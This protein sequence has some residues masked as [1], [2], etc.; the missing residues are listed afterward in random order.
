MTLV[1]PPAGSQRSSVDRVW[2]ALDAGGFKPESI[3][4]DKFMALCP[5]HGDSNR[6]LS[7]K[8]ESR[9][10]MTMLH[11]F[12]CQAEYR[13]IAA[14]IHLAPS[15]LF[16]E[17]LPE[18]ERGERKK[19]TPRTKFVPTHKVP[20][21]I[22]EDD[23]AG[24][25]ERLKKATWQRVLTYPY[26]DSKG[27]VIE[28]VIREQTVLDG[29]T[30]K[31]FRQRF[32]GDK[33]RW[34]TKKPEWF[35]P[36]LY[37]H[38]QLLEAIAAGSPVW[39]VEGEKDAD[40]A[41]AAGL[42][43]TTNAQ[44]A[45]SF[46]EELIDV[47]A[48][49]TVKVVVDRDAAGYKRGVTMHRLL[50]GVAASVTLLRPAVDEDKSDLS[51]HLEAG[52]G[53]DELEEITAR[54]SAL[55]AAVG[56][57]HRTIKAV[58]VCRR[59]I[60][61]HLERIPAAGAA[62]PQHR[63]AAETWAT[64]SDI[65][66]RRMVDALTKARIEY[67]G[68]D[69]ITHAALNDADAII[70][71]A[72]EIAREAHELAEVRTPVSI[73]AWRDQGQ[74][75]APIEAVSDDDGDDQQP[76]R[77]TGHEFIP[78]DDGTPNIGTEYRVRN[79]QTV[80]VKYVP[81]EEGGWKPRFHLI[82]D[83]WAEILSAS[84]EDDGD[85]AT[86]SPLS[87]MIVEFSR[88]SRDPETG[89]PLYDEN[90]EVIVERQV[91]VWDEE[92]LREGK[93]TNHLGWPGMLEDSSRRGR[94]MAWNAIHR[95]RRAPS[96]FNRIYT[97]TG[98]RKTDLG[99]FFVHGG[100]AITSQGHLDVD[101]RMPSSIQKLTVPEPTL[102][103]KVLREA[104]IRGTVSLREKLP[105][106][107]IAPLLGLVWEAPFA[108]V[109]L[110][111][112]LEGAPGSGKSSC[113]RQAMHYFAPELTDRVGASKTIL[114]ATQAGGS[115][116]GMIRLLAQHV[117]H[118]PVLA[119]DFVDAQ[120]ARKAEAKI[121]NFARAIF[122]RAPRVIG[123]AR[124]GTSESKPIDAS[125][126][127]TGQV[128]L[129]GSGLQ[130]VFTID[131]S[132]GD[133]VDTPK[134][135]ADL[136]KKDRR[137][138]RAVLGA[139]LI[140]WL[141]KHRR[142]LEAEF[143]D[144]DTPGR[145][146]NEALSAMWLE[147]ISPLPHS[148]GA[149]GRMT[150]AA[151]AATHGIHIMLRMLVDVD[152]IT[153]D[154]ANEFLEWAIDG[155]LTAIRR[156]DHGAGD[157]GMTT[158]EL[159]REGLATNMAHLTT[160]EGEAPEHAQQF[161][162]TL[163]G[164]PPHDMLLPNGPRIGAIKGTGADAKLLLHP[165]VTYELISRVARG[166]G[167]SLSDTPMSIGSSFIAH[168]WVVPDNG[169]K[170]AVGRRIE[171][172][173]QRVW[174]IPLTVL[175]GAD[176]DDGTP[177]PENG[178]TG[179][180]QPSEGPTT[181]QTPSLFDVDPA[182]AGERPRREPAVDKPET[183]AAAGPDASA[184]PT[185]S[186]PSAP[187]PAAARPTAP[188]KTTSPFAAAV[189]VLHVDGLWMP[190]G[191]RLELP[192]PLRHLG[193]VA[194]LIAHLR[195]GVKNGWKNEDGQLFVT[196]GAAQQL[197]LPMEDLPKPGTF[198]FTEELK[199]RTKD[200][201]FITDAIDAGWQVGGTERSLNATTRVWHP[202]NPQLRGRFVLIPA[203]KDDFAP[204]MA[205][206]T[207]PA[208]VA[209][210]LQRFADALGA[211]YAVSAS[212]T[213]LDLMMTTAPSKEQRLLRFAPSEPVPP[214]EI[215]TLEA[216]INWQRKPTEE[217]LT[218]RYVHGFDRGGS[219]LAGVAGL[220][221]GVGAPTYLPE[222]TPITFDKNTPGYWRV[223]MPEKAEWLTPNPLDPRNRDEDTTGQLTWVS[224]PTLEIA[225]DCGYSFEIQEA[226]VWE[227]HTRLLDTWYERVRD[228]RTALDTGDPDDT[229][230]RDLLK[231]LY[232]R[233]L[234]LMASHEHHRGRDGYAPERYH[235]IQAKARAAI[236]RRIHQIGKNTGRWPVAIIAD[237]VLY[238]S[239]EID[240]AKAWPGEARNFGRGLGQFKPEGF[241]ELAG[242][243]KFLTG[244]GRYEG[245][246]FLDQELI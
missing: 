183:P 17:P 124:G 67:S 221:L 86:A 69:P 90:G 129:H 5:V 177:A 42:V 146:S 225:L 230:A 142:A 173:L 164:N 72:A 116:I 222:G 7:V 223:P 93:W 244:R 174:E 53:V 212:T 70:E 18:N 22:T 214:A 198:D 29:V 110:I 15:D 191:E 180:Q 133:I 156:Q 83:G 205:G 3:R 10:G 184:Q 215:A 64:E 226:Y 123:K 140:Q 155:I 47:F 240:P 63:E 114:S 37:H 187:A 150:K 206:A 143:F 85:D 13:D 12:T 138:A 75:V 108:P 162:W 50:K 99:D 213:G 151:V 35:T 203:L 197:G 186:T 73:T 20:R 218:H 87:E 219:Y 179:P 171:G 208:D 152:A 176:G 217:G 58:D 169:G 4:G 88:W 147:R 207:G 194:Q 94:D 216:D 68:D 98:W 1:S 65:R 48:G 246:E 242:H 6:S 74:N 30:H 149:K 201:P 165:R 61:A 118:M 131:I 81:D 32:M 166:A 243:L 106:R 122:D 196:L 27:D 2:N 56:D 11:C 92:V 79:G 16:D 26:A 144:E 170:S 130:R 71:A 233:G 41:I 236:I 89:R 231:N 200:I 28:E 119:D 36:V 229:A 158:I 238:T 84:L 190:S 182:D 44:G 128:G 185:T 163:R 62:A 192:F 210:R 189:A 239:N 136:E 211:P 167:E 181:P 54:Q 234:G 178:S 77:F 245:K 220:Q 49:A 24:L 241:T 199:K 188:A 126:I 9:R 224:T 148:D 111:T 132:P 209:R 46:P 51:D 159:I 34:L 33:G 60:R 137:Q 112:Y 82:M 14:A 91:V 125:V 21:R 101:V 115:F 40:N 52:L 100:G 145:S 25:E 157:P 161:G 76:P 120:D 43:A 172:V 204:I 109:P 227:Q 175:T 97:A 121:D 139:A 113:G 57:A 107:V 232:T 80:Q 45:G 237:T 117:S 228:A 78:G 19:R 193:D 59:E 195:L 235:A 103:P 104:W 105:A 66:F 96:S 102:D 153:R 160:T 127:A 8:W 202:E 39:I 95:A 154:E 135:F 38:T 31:R 134:T 23:D 55:L 168:G 141:C